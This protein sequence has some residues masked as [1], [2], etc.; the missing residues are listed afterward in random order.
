MV[1]EL[2][3]GYGKVSWGLK[4]SIPSLRTCFEVLLE[5]KYDSVFARRYVEK[6]CF[7]CVFMCAFADR[8]FKEI[9]H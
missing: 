4:E 8:G 7:V 6:L 5:K 1:L 2:H 3:P 9:V